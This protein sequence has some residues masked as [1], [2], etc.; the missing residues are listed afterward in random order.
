MHYINSR[1]PNAMKFKKEFL[2]FPLDQRYKSE[3]LDEMKKRI[4]TVLKKNK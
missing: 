4:K 1:Y 2:A 3:D